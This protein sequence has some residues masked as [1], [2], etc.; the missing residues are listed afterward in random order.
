MIIQKVGVK[1]PNVNPMYTFTK[2]DDMAYGKGNVLFAI[3]SDRVE[4][5]YID[6]FTSA[7][8]GY[9]FKDDTCFGAY[10]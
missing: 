1:S 5:D 10:Q 8:C 9:S 2:I 6:N 7:F 3:I 4:T